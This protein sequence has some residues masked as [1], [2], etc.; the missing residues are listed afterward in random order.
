MTLRLKFTPRAKRELTRVADWW[1]VER[2]SAPELVLDEL[3]AALATLAAAPHI[4][5]VYARARPGTRRFL[6]T[7]TRL[8]VYY[9]VRG[10][11]LV[12]LSVWSSVRGAGPRL[13]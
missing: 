10:A 3:E 11:D 6:L 9:T 7:Q 2:P 4:G 12:V 5:V 1:R 8:H 13:R